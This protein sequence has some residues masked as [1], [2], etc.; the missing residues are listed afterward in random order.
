MRYLFRTSHSL[1]PAPLAALL[2]DFRLTPLD[3]VLRAELATLAPNLMT[4]HGR[5]ISAQTGR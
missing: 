1:D 3:E 2:P 4:P 5:S